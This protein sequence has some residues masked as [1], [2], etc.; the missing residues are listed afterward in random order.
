MSLNC[1]NTRD[2]VAMYMDGAVSER[3]RHDIRHH[4]RGCKECSRFYHDYKHLIEKK[5]KLKE[6]LGFDKNF[7]ALA[8]RMK[9]KEH[10]KLTALLSS[11]I[12]VIAATLLVSKS[13]FTQTGRRKPARK[14]KH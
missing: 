1:E 4:L 8:K 10:I 5:K 9:R 7:A 12:S 6:E 13:L 3:T 2:F 14:H 11:F